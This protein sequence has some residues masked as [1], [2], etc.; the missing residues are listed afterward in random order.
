MLLKHNLPV[1]ENLIKNGEFTPD[2]G[3]MATIELL[4]EKE[5]FEAIVA[6]ND[7]M[8]IAAMEVLKKYKIKIPKDVAVVGFDN[9]EE[10][11]IH[12]PSLTTIDQGR[13]KQG[14]QALKMLIDSLDGKKGGKNKPISPQLKIR[15]SCGCSPK[16]GLS[17]NNTV[18]RLRV[19]IR[20]KIEIQKQLAL[21]REIGDDLSTATDFDQLLEILST[22]IPL[23]GIR[24][25]YIAFYSRIAKKQM[26]DRNSDLLSSKFS[27]IKLAIKNGNRI[28]LKKPFQT[29]LILPNDELLSHERFSIVVEPLYFRDHKFGYAL[30]KIGPKEGVIFEE[31]R[32]LISRAIKVIY[33]IKEIEK[34]KEELSRTKLLVN[35]RTALALIGMANSIWGHAIRSKAITIRDEIGLIKLNH[36]KNKESLEKIK[37]LASEILIKPITSSPSFKS[38][39]L[40]SINQFIKKRINILNNNPNYHS[41]RF[42]TSFSNMT[43]PFVRYSEEWLKQIFDILIDNAKEAMQNSTLK[44]IKIKTCLNNNYIEI[45]FSDT[46][47][48]IDKKTQSQI[49]KKPIK[50]FKNQ[51]GLGI[52]L[53]M[54]QAI[55]QVFKGDICLSNSSEKGTTFIIKLPLEFTTKIKR[56]IN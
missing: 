13:Q 4:D 18:K 28:E 23:L 52:G 11:R 51:R 40:I 22:K 9:I 2:S 14:E 10:A 32:G 3:K 50:K 48:G 41:I 30:F 55:L 44:E 35:A 7:N 5:P 6:A 38:A 56:G 26:L 47:L 19:Q 8:A 16:H 1:N 43:K 31:L 24:T 15:E 27:E 34:K 33:L 17:L 37:Q 36:N 54:V 29:S 42:T 46:G 39:T 25:F 12:H 53:L 20:Q 21:L 45:Y 49:F